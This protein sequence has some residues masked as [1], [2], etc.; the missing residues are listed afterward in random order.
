MIEQLRFNDKSKAE[1]LQFLQAYQKAIDASIIC[2][3]TN[4]EGII[5]YANQKF[6]DSSKY[7]KEELLG[8]NHRILN[9][10][11][12]PDYFFKE[13]WE[14]ISSG[15]M[16]RKE[17]KSRAKDGSYFWQDSLILPVYDGL[18][19]IT[20]YFS[21]RIPIDDRKKAEEDR[22]QRIKEL[23]TLLFKISHELRQPVTQILGITHLLSDA[24]IQ[25]EELK[26]FVTAMHHSAKQLDRYTK[27]VTVALT[28]MRNSENGKA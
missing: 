14:T 7:K 9:A 25:E 4:A 5:I 23:E 27:E 11:Y 20:L 26:T 17:V 13:M 28:A 16:W 6:C 1:L 8:Q 3:I 2:S 18:H 22:E 10:G 19:Q 21:I 15:E 24:V 12:H